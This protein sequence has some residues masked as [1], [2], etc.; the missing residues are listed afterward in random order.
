MIAAFQYRC[1]R[2]GKIENNPK[3]G[4]KDG[5]ATIAT[6]HLLNAT[7]GTTKELIGPHMHSFHWC[8]DNGRGISDL[9]GY[10]LENP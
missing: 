1:R 5:D 9:I 7:L 6:M 10:E 3:M 2:C 8:K 4:V